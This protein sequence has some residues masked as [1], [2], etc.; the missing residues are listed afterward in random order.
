[1]FGDVNGDGILEVVVGTASGLMAVLSGISG[2]DVAPFPF[3][4][5]GS[6][7][8]QVHDCDMACN[9]AVLSGTATGA[10]ADGHHRGT[11]S[12]VMGFEQPKPLA[13]VMLM[14]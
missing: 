12:S 11:A 7:K 2:K 8:S 4:T 3:R 10:L 5:H 13:P 9:S 1:M 14:P 6:I